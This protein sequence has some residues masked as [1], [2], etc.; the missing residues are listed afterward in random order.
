MKPFDISGRFSCGQAAA[1]LRI[2]RQRFI[3]LD[4]RHRYF[5]IFLRSG[6]LPVDRQIGSVYAEW[7]KPD[8]TD[9][10]AGFGAKQRR[11]SVR[12]LVENSWR[13]RGGVVQGKA[14]EHRSSDWQH[15][16]SQASACQ[17]CWPDRPTDGGTSPRERREHPNQQS[18]SCGIRRVRARSCHQR[19]GG[20]FHGGRGIFER[21]QWR[22]D[23]DCR[24]RGRGHDQPCRTEAASSARRAERSGLSAA[25]GLHRTVCGRQTAGRPS[26]EFRLRVCSGVP[27]GRQ[28]L[29]AVVPGYSS[30][31]AGSPLFLTVFA[32][33]GCPALIFRRNP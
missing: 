6:R 30:K 26:P 32:V 10:P 27:R 17:H 23:C 21:A 22:A 5:A 14:Y 9:F 2:A 16:R 25:A 8:N 15:I 29:F 1:T 18:L 13:I 4:R 20:G 31:S 7:N 11:G 28:T 12:T 19:T 33:S 24:P 3:G